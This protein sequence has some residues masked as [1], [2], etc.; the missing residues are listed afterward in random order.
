[1]SR[2]SRVC[3]EENGD[4]RT[5]ARPRRGTTG[6]EMTAREHRYTCWTV[7][8]CTRMSAIRSFSFASE[9]K[10][11]KDTLPSLAGVE[12]C[13]SGGI[14]MTQGCCRTCLADKRSGARTSIR[15]TR[16][17]AAPETRLHTSVEKSI[18]PREMFSKRSSRRARRGPSHSPVRSCRKMAP[19]PSKECVK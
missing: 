9:T 19:C 17:F 2:R 6:N 18:F 3:T 5:D 4:A 11:S 16:S 15:A 7:P 13:V 1:M 14:C 12:S 8:E 10:L